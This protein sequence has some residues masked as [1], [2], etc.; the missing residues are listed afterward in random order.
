[1][2]KVNFSILISQIYKMTLDLQRVF[3]NHRIS[4]LKSC[5]RPEM[6][7]YGTRRALGKLA[8]LKKNS[9]TRTSSVSSSESMTSSTV[10]H[11]QP[12]RRYPK[13]SV[14]SEACRNRGSGHDYQN[15]SDADEQ[16]SLV[17]DEDRGRSISVD[18]SISSEEVVLA[19]PSASR[20]QT[21]SMASKKGKKVGRVSCSEENGFGMTLRTRGTKRQ[22]E[23]DSGSDEEESGSEADENDQEDESESDNLSLDVEQ[24]EDE[25]YEE[26]E[27]EEEGVEPTVTTRTLRTRSGRLQSLEVAK[28]PRKRRR[29]MSSDSD[30][31]LTYRPSHFLTRSSRSGRVVKANTKYS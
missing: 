9:K 11:R 23:Q 19:P 20:R 7:L 25:E 31:D 28:S 15:W 26:E 12:Q 30:E 1:M 14:V 2:R 17:D 4:F 29:K 3:D 5:P 13:R 16:Q 27:E 21:R 22:L 8:T 6:H 10:S 18:V 24:E